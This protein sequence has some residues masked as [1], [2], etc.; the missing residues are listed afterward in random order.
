[1]RGRIPRSTS[2]APTRRI[3]QSWQERGFRRSF[4]Q[5]SISLLLL[6]VTPAAPTPFG[7]PLFRGSETERLILFQ[8][9]HRSPSKN[10]PSIVTIRSVIT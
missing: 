8:I 10:A 1:M 9:A 6:A 2:N 7:K 3:A 4:L 5:P